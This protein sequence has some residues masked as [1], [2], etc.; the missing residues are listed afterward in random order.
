VKKFFLTFSCDLTPIP[1]P[2]GRGVLQKKIFLPFSDP[3]KGPGDEVK[4]IRNNVRISLYLMI[5]LYAMSC[6]AADSSGTKFRLSVGA[7]GGYTHLITYQNQ[8][9]STE[10][11]EHLSH[12]ILYPSLSIGREI[13]P[14]FALFLEYAHLFY[15]TYQISG[16]IPHM[17]SI[18][19]KATI[20]PSEK[21]RNIFLSFSFGYYHLLF[22]MV[23]YVPDKNAQPIDSLHPATIGHLVGWYS[24]PGLGTT[25]SCGY[26]VN[27]H[28]RVQL[29]MDYLIH[30]FGISMNRTEIDANDPSN[31]IKNFGPSS[32]GENWFN[33]LIG[34]S[35]F[36][37]IF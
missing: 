2:N 9:D 30:I 17:P 23:E 28:F 18:S 8:F 37:D 13:N 10:R 20:N 35:A 34:L 25:V 36:W 4:G 26:R 3:E 14:R 22:P 32:F 31:T 6:L 1:S 27:N 5:L 21:N 15:I 16:N 12:A 29:D 11:I 24:R 19:V 33:I 7:G